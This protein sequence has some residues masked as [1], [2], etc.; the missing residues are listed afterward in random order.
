MNCDDNETELS[1][2]IRAITLRHENKIGTNSMKIS[3]SLACTMLAKGTHV[4]N[5]CAPP[6]SPLGN[7]HR[8]NRN[9]P[10]QTND[11][12]TLRETVPLG[13]KHPMDKRKNLDRILEHSS[14]DIGEIEYVSMARVLRHA[15]AQG[16]GRQ[17][18]QFEMKILFCL[19]K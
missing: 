3:N 2:R 14:R 12:R 19:F 17:L 18:T 11:S 6:H 10:V 13:P 8:L 15:I 1:N 9:Q 5:A 16:Y 4:C 7:P